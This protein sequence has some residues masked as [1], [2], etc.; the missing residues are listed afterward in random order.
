M[1]NPIVKDAAARATARFG[2][3]NE[4]QGNGVPAAGG[5]EKARPRSETVQGK[6]E[7]FGRVVGG[8]QW[9][10]CKRELA[11]NLRVLCSNNKVV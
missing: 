5:L 6:E 2:R 4:K 11:L 7:G 8:Q 3:G 1:L 10:A 9:I